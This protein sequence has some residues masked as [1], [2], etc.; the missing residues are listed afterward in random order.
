MLGGGPHPPMGR[1][2]FE[3]HTSAWPD[4]PVVDM[5]NFIR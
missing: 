3:G 4:L 5:V 1:G 2:T